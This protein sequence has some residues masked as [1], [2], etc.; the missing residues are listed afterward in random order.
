M[1]GPTDRN[2]LR[3]ETGPYLRR[4]ADDPINWQPWDEKALRTAQRH[5]AP[6]FL[7]IGQLT[8]PW[9]QRMQTE[10]FSDM[11]VAGLLNEHYV[12]VAVD[13]VNRPD[14]DTL[15][16]TVCRIVNNNEGW[17]LSVWLTPEQEPFYVGTYFP[18][19]GEDWA[20]RFGDVLELVADKWSSPEVRNAVETR[21]EEWT[22][23]AREEI[24][25][26]PQRGAH[27]HAG[28]G[29]T[30]GRI[31][32]VAVRTA[33]HEDGG[34]GTDG[35]VLESARVRL[36]LS[37]G[38]GVAD[39]EYTG[40]ATSA[41][42]GIADGAVH[43]Q[44]GGGFFRSA[45]NSDWS[46]PRGGK[47]LETNADAIRAYLAGHV[48]TGNERYAT[49]AS[50][51]LSFVDRELGEPNGGFRLGVGGADWTEHDPDDRSEREQYYG[52]TRRSVRSVLDDEADVQLACDRYGIDA[53]GAAETSI[54]TLATSVSDL[55]EERNEPETV[56]AEQ[57]DRIRET[58]LSDRTGRRRPPRDERIV[59]G[60]NGQAV[61]AF[62]EAGTVLDA[63]Y[64]GRAEDALSF[65]RERLW[66]GDRLD[67][68]Y[69]EGDGDPRGEPFLEDYAFVGRGAVACYGTTGSLDALTFALD[70]AD[71]I[72][73]DFFVEHEGRLRAHPDRSE[74]L[75]VSPE[76]SRDWDAPSPIA[77]AIDLLSIADRFTRTDRFGTA[78]V[79]IADTY[80]RRIPTD[81]L[82]HHS[83]AMAS[84]RL[85]SGLTEITVSTDA[86]PSC[87]PRFV[88]DLSRYESLLAPRPATEEG[89]TAWLERLDLDETPPVW[90][91]RE[92][93][94]EPTIHD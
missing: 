48:A 67:G 30:L 80:G 34:W 88:N 5:D 75:I 77:A 22:S 94:D 35:K 13:R 25:T 57:L 17:P 49:V 68:R 2:R 89:L 62:A 50:R 19:E 59:A 15:Y 6:I 14:L 71:A 18:P 32:D 76:E 27:T 70:L 39:G 44:V 58:L 61:H 78:A 84:D 11:E 53:E 43:D 21:G 28:D 90:A 36:L 16:R 37:V 92:V 87:W 86:V 72:V 20:P 33:D 83:L 38:D 10:S 41:L 46:A 45:T 4:L 93:G 23:Y 31:A 47:C 81:L 51:A 9:C 91:G 65:V 7:S 52:W 74:T 29:G 40:T 24:E 60:S 79:S 1:T 64:A 63:T 85:H 8:S 12:P 82:R 73:A 26:V 42:D 69:V 54:P 3:A 56:V 66:N 55:A